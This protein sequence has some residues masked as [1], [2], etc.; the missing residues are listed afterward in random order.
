MFQ[1]TI[2]SNAKLFGILDSFI[3]RKKHSV[4]PDYD[5]PAILTSRLNSFFI[6][7]ID[8]IKAEFPV[9]L[10]ADLPPYS[11]HSIDSVVLLFWIILIL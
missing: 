5:S 8:L 1:V 4:L 6:D 7:N 3:G 2:R 11:V 10:E 9:L